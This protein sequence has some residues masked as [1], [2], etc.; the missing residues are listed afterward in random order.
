[1]MDELRAAA[2]Q[3]LQRENARRQ[4]IDRVLDLAADDT[5]IMEHLLGLASDSNGGEDVM[6]D[7]NGP[8]D[9]LAFVP[10]G[11]ILVAPEYMQFPATSATKYELI[12]RAFYR[13]GRQHRLMFVPHESTVWHGVALIYTDI[14][15]QEAGYER[16]LFGGEDSVRV[17]APIVALQEDDY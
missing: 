4:E 16:I 13:A 10:N 9:G 2:L 8:G 1:M 3:V 15:A 6:I 17:L 5:L 7:S 14:I 11:A 12:Q